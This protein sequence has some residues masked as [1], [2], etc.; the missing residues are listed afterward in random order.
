MKYNYSFDRKWVRFGGVERNLLKLDSGSYE[1]KMEQ[2]N[3]YVL[4]IYKFN[5]SMNGQ[6]RVHCG[7]PANGYTDPVTVNLPGLCVFLNWK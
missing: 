6:N 3:K 7:Y 5:V 4:T 1:E 2:H